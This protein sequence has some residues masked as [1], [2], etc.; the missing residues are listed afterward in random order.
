M[1][2]TNA[3][4]RKT[5]VVATLITAL[6]VSGAPT[7]EVEPP[8][9]RAVAAGNV[10]LVQ[11][12]LRAGADVN[13]PTAYG[14]TPIALAVMEGSRAVVEALLQAG[15][16]P[17]AA[18]DDGE[19]VLMSAA[20]AGHLPVVELLLSRGANPNTRD[21]WRGQTALTRAAG[22]NHAG[23]VAALVRGGADPNATDDLLEFWQ[24]VPSEQATPKIVMPKG[25]MAVL[26]YAA[27]Q[28]ALEAVRALTAAPG[29][30]LNRADPDGVNALLYA[31]LNGHFDVAGHLLEAGADPNKAD[32]YGRTV[33]F[34]AIEMSRP[35]REPRPVPQTTNRITPLALARLALV[36]GADANPRITGR[37][38]NRCPLGCV[39]SASEGATPLWRAARTGDTEA[40]RL[41]LEAGSDVRAAAGDG[42][43]P[44]MMAAGLGWRDD[45]VLATEDESIA[46]I[47]QLLA[48][49]AA[50]SDTTKNGDTALHGAAGRGSE[51]VI[52]FLVSSGADLQ[53]Q[54]TSNRTPLDVAMGRGSKVRT[55]GGAATDPVVRE[56]AVR[57]LKELIGE[58]R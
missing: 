45:R 54:D 15:A 41:L 10:P 23:V 26:H 33:L 25:G 28:G 35:D 8:L 14:V 53:A 48:A 47:K 43:T 1:P 50:I 58:S 2:H 3:L 49:G 20:A 57:V 18:N 27:R 38:P 40:V 42:S 12:L 55:G 11:Q 5:T 44:L 51:P 9:H 22:E 32:N 16:N 21:T 39:A 31:T 37:I 46:V 24:M 34:A 29:I 13:H 30:D 36:K 56:G 7:A 52:R 19:T 6:L 17:N 4:R